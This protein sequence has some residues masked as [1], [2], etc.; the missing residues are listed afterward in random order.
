MN[1]RR[2]LLLAGIHLV[3]A[4]T[5][6]VWMEARDAQFLRDSQESTAEAAREAASR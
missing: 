1:W 6:I 3:V 4:G 5:L 2:G